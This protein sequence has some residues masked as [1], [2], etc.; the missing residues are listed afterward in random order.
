MVTFQKT[1][2]LN[3][4]EDINNLLWDID[5]KISKIAKEKLDSQKFGFSPKSNKDEVFIL[6]SYRRIL[7]TR[8]SNSSCLTGIN[9][10]DIVNVIK[11]YLTSGKVSKIKSNSF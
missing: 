2:T 11:Q 6:T 7:N 4:S 3:F 1:Q 8:H 5:S 10:D 9:I